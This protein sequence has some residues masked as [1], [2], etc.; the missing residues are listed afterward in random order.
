MIKL[1]TRFSIFIYFVLFFNIL[2]H[3]QDEPDEPIINIMV[4]SGG[5]IDFKIYSLYYYENGMSL[6]WG[7]LTLEYDTTDV[8]Q[9]GEWYLELRAQD[10]EFLCSNPDQSLSLDNVTLEVEDIGT[11][12]NFEGDELQADEIT[13]TDSWQLIVD[14]ADSGFYKLKI[15]YHLASLLGHP[16]GY[17]NTIL[18][19][20]MTNQN[21]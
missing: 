3:G 10:S 8:S 9:P 18:E 13:L 6:D 2:V 16:P 19:F 4:E 17:Y 20:R 12:D 11:E 5:N 14:G 15:T 1:C 21:E 7:V